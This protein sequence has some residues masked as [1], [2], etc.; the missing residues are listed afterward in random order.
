LLVGIK[1]E[2]GG[3]TLFLLRRHGERFESL[4]SLPCGW[5]EM[6]G[7]YQLDAANP[8]PIE[9]LP[10]W[11]ELQN[12]KVGIAPYWW[13]VKG[14]DFFVWATTLRA[15]LGIAEP[16][17]R[18]FVHR[19]PDRPREE[20]YFGMW[21]QEQRSL[22]LAKHDCLISYGNTKA[23]EPLMERIRQWVDLGMPTGASFRL[24]VYRVGAPVTARTRQWL[25]RRKESQFLWILD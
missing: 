25:V 1:S 6:R 12:Q 9:A 20:R 13:G 17:F 15:F 23:K 8:Q 18:T 14:K 4:D 21:D 11:T 16:S 5:V 2:G 22:V 7:K 19:A 10:A 24:H 3:D